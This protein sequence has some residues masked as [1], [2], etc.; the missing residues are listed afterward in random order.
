LLTILA[1][2]L[3]TNPEAPAIEMGH[4]KLSYR[5]LW[6]R[7]AAL[8]NR[9]GQAGVVAGD[10]VGVC[11]RPNIDRVTAF[12]ATLRLGAVYLPLDP[13]LPEQRLTYMLSDSSARVV[14]VNA[15]SPA[16]PNGAQ[17]SYRVT[18]WMR[19]RYLIWKLQFPMR[20][21]SWPI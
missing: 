10:V 16:L 17:H 21:A 19:I 12:W 6:Q 8:E 13:A 14:I 18:F 1:S 9:L 2:H 3:R 15:A 5:E 20:Q 11:L 7:A 4:R